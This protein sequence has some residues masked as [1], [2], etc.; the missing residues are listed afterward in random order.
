MP[1]TELCSQNI[2]HLIY[3]TVNISLLTLTRFDFFFFLHPFCPTTSAGQNI[4]LLIKIHVTSQWQEDNGNQLMLPSGSLL[5]A[6]TEQT[7]YHTI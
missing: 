4:N 5:F 6:Q 2:L 7:N 3:T 1:E